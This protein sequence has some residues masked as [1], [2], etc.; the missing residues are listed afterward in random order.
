[1]KVKRYLNDT[2][3]SRE[4][5]YSQKIVNDT[6]NRIFTNVKKRIDMQDK[7]QNIHNTVAS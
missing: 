7:A 2:L 3:I 4:E 6:L 1:M 5:L